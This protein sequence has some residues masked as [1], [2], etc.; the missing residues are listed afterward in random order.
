MKIL[1][2]VDCTQASLHEAKKAA[3]LAK[4]YQ[5]PIKFIGIISPGDQRA[6]NRYIRLWQQVDGS[7]LKK[8]LR[9]TNSKAANARLWTKAFFMIHSLIS[10]LD[11]TGCQIECEVLVGKP[12][13]SVF[14]I[15]EN[16]K[17][18]L[19]IISDSLLKHLHSCKAIS[20]APCPVQVVNSNG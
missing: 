19:I 15:A 20:K 5:C 4:T 14:S 17:A 10:E 9:I 8:S 18:G 11:C 16:D 13:D 6:H 1:L 2:P 7:I 3:D 12:F